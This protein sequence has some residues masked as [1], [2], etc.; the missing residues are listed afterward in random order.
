MTRENAPR[1]RPT[2]TACQARSPRPHHEERRISQP[3]RARHEV[4]GNE[5]PLPRFGSP[6][7]SEAPAPG[8]HSVPRAPR[9]T[10]GLTY[11]K[12]APVGGLP[13]MP[14]GRLVGM[15]FSPCGETHSRVCGT[16]EFLGAPA[17]NFPMTKRHRNVWYNQNRQAFVRGRYMDLPT[18]MGRL[19]PVAFFRRH[20]LAKSA[21]FGSVLG[22]RFGPGSG[23]DLLPEYAPEHV[24]SL[25]GPVGV[26]QPKGG[27]TGF[28]AAV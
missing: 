21:H 13:A 27:A 8:R 14:R 15:R 28:M 20:H 6:L 23:V 3:R 24:L 9:Y 18:E 17:T 22:D 19:Q 5:W 16:A 12:V 1:L 7:S 4:R 26:E 2:Q 25:F 10:F 11:S